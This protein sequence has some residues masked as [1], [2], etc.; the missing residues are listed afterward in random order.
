MESREL[1]HRIVS[2]HQ[3]AVV[4]NDV[5]LGAWLVDTSQFK[6]AE[7]VLLAAES[8]REKLDPTSHC[9][10]LK[11]LMAL[12]IAWGAEE[13]AKEWREAHILACTAESQP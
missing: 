12:Y 4:E 2:A 13:P 1:Y 6:E 10:V 8:L 7:Q 5:R 9:A 3:S 11:G